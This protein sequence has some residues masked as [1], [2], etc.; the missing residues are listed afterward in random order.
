MTGGVSE[1]TRGDGGCGAGDRNEGGGRLHDDVLTGGS[2]F[3]LTVSWYVSV[4]LGLVNTESEKLVDD[5]KM[6]IR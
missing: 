1:R 5:G 3:C 2:V 6:K 4:I